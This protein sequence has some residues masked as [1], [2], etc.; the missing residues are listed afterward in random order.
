MLST[1]N[2]KDIKDIK[3]EYLKGLKFHYVDEMIDVLE[4][5][6]LQEKVKHPVDLTVR[7]ELMITTN[8][9]N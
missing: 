7:K 3:A 5:A 6:L 8:P 1:D 2:E 4:F 9:V